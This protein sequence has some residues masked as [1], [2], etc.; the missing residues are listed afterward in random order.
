MKY[1]KH[2]AIN[3]IQGKRPKAKGK[4]ELPV[5]WSGD[6]LLVTEKRRQ[7]I[8]Q[9]LVV[10]LMIGLLMPFAAIAQEDCE[11]KPK[12]KLAGRKLDLP[13]P[14]ATPP[15]IVDA[16]QNPSAA[17]PAANPTSQDSQASQ[18][19]LPS[20]D[21]VGVNVA[22]QTPISL[23][24]AIAL[25]LANNKDIN[26]SRLD[27]E[28]ARFD[29]TGAKGV[30]DPK[31]AV[32]SYYEHRETPVSSIIGG[33]ASGKLTA[34]D[35]TSVARLSGNTPLAGG[36]YQIDFSSGR[37]TTD[38][39]FA[40]L[41]PQYPSGVSVTYTQPLLKG[42][43]TDDNRRRIEIA[44]K[45]LSLTDSQFRQRA[46][47]VITRVQQAYWDLVFALRNL[48][49]Q[50]DAVTQARSQLE[51]NRRQVAQGTLAPIDIVSAEAQ[52]T[53]FEQ[54]VF[55]AQEGVTRAENNLKLLMLPERTAQLWA[56]ALLPT[57]A[58]DLDVPRVELPEAV[59]IAL[60][61]RPE[62]EQV[63]RSA[64]INQINQKF[65]HNQLKPQ[66]DL[67][68]VYTSAG[69]AGSLAQ[70][71]PNPFTAGTIALTERVNQLS[72]LAGLPVLPPTQSSGSIPALLV[73]GTGQSLSNLF[74]LNFPTA[75]VGIRFSLPIGN[76][77][78]E[79]NLG[80]SLAE[81]RKIQ[82]QRQQLEQSIEADVRNT[83]QAVRSAQA[84]LMSAGA[85][86][87]ATEKQYESEQR[88]FQA[89]LSTVFLV[90]QRQQELIAARG[91]EV[92]AQTDLNKA[93]ADFQRA[94]GSTFKAH[95]IT[96]KS[97]ADA[98]QL[99]QTVKQ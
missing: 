31:L 53:L 23:D 2:P 67:F 58:V 13:D 56:K 50:N 14:N 70:R 97:D 96:V 92:Q 33:S 24:E 65:F 37:Q 72:Q 45:N 74:G 90:L 76:R 15:K 85:S 98:P 28:M 75:R 95:N 83:L 54:N 64:E 30:Y 88:K 86:R 48:Q 7:V 27:V 38:N 6:F 40:S 49:V 60:A 80:R 19:P 66:I 46:I 9:L 94:T 61:S 77:T 3:F 36:V 29:L 81:G 12:S 11:N 87:D 26:A 8:S 41:N 1:P 4:S 93:I 21:R 52:M 71:G 91:R 62:L 25:A 22:E 63:A 17:T 89:G 79:A 10:C 57:T 43:T 32:E 59:S 44:K 99:E 20:A 78:A 47:E 55:V 73:G 5:N 69:L 82:N 51:S 18:R 68:G 39:Q 16:K 34:T 84:R 35:S 42:L